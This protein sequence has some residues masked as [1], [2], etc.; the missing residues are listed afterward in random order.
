MTV[1]VKPRFL[2]SPEFLTGRNGFSEKSPDLD[3]FDWAYSR[4][5]HSQNSTHFSEKPICFDGNAIGKRLKPKVL[6]KK[7]KKKN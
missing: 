3:V 4:I 2:G 5:F 7:I 6:K 1:H